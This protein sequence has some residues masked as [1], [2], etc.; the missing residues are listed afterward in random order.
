MENNKLMQEPY[1]ENIYPKQGVKSE[2]YASII[3]LYLLVKILEESF[4]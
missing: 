3:Y 4:F 2:S 1:S